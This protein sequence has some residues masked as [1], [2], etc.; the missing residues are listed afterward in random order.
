MNIERS[1]N[2]LHAGFGRAEDQPPRKFLEMAVNKG[3]YAGERLDFQKW[4]QMLD[5]YY[6]I[7][8]WDKKTGWPTKKTLIDLGLKQILE[9]LVQQGIDLPEDADPR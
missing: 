7:H 4:N 9:K 6:D 2:L 3:P 8:R 1:F 5:E